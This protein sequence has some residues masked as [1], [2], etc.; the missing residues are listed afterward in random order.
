VFVLARPAQK[1]LVEESKLGIDIILAV[2]ISASMD[3]ND[4]LPSRA[5][6]SQGVI[7]DFLERVDE[8]NRVGLVGFSGSAVTFSPLTFDYNILKEYIDKLS[9]EESFDLIQG[10][11]GTAIGDAILLSVSKFQQDIERTRVIILITDGRANS[12][13]D[14]LD[15]ADFAKD[16]EAR[17][18]TIF[19]NQFSDRQA[20]ST[21][22]TI[23]SKTGG[24]S[25]H[26]E[27]SRGLESVFKEIE[28][29][30]KTEL[31]LPEEYI[32]H[33]DPNLFIS[34]A[35]ILFVIFCLIKSLKYSRI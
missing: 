16:E 21:L 6:A 29:S 30:E 34:L 5:E 10:A 26:V 20:L 24:I 2:D 14:P 3:F 23:S 31:E 7:R 22:E 35:G 13:V 11:G 18:H 4:I 9:F 25:E 33:D 27:S 19:V 1:E 28:E 8:N 17:I 32:L 12:G 15:A